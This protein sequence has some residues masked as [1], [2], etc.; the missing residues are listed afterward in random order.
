MFKLQ[1][2]RTEEERTARR[3]AGYEDFVL[4]GGEVWRAVG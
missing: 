2:P 3:T 1:V 4:R